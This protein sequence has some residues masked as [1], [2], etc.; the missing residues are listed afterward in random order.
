LHSDEGSSV[1]NWSEDSDVSK[2]SL[3]RAEIEQNRM[4][5]HFKNIFSE[6]WKIL[7]EVTAH[8]EG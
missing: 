4:K 8:G 6:W 2:T 5:F 7:P 1:E 3:E